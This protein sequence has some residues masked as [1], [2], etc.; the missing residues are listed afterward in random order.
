MV[1]EREP[2]SP[3]RTVWSAGRRHGAESKRAGSAV[4]PRERVRRVSPGPEKRI[5][6]QAGSAR[7]VTRAVES[8]PAQHAAPS[9]PGFDRRIR[10]RVRNLQVAADL[11]SEELID[12]A[13]PRHGGHFARRGVHI[14]RM[15][16]A[17]AKQ[18]A[19]MGL[20]MTDEI[21]PLHAVSN[22]GSRMTS[23]PC[24]S[25]ATKFRFASS[26]NS[27]ASRRFARASSSVAP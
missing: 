27:T 15:V 19:S 21:N 1:G 24:D 4:L 2:G 12:F 26:T 20:K 10:L 3:K 17:L 6:R 25:S 16:T 8:V 22:S 11:A 18:P 14:D 9:F 13:M 23:A 7:K 5:L